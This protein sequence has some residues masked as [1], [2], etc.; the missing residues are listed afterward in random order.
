[1]R[2]VGVHDAFGQSGEPAEL[3][4]HYEMDVMSI[5]VAAKSLL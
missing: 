4:T 3:I 1:M 2:F 5:V